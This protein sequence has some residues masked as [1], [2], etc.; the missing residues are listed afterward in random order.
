MGAKG[1]FML[2]K[3]APYFVITPSNP[4]VF[5]IWLLEYYE[6]GIFLD[7]F[8]TSFNTGF[9]SPDASY[10][11]RFPFHRRCNKPNGLRR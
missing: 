2:Y 9:L 1:I 11:K 7:I 5:R 10:L 3:N 8:F 4:F 6:G